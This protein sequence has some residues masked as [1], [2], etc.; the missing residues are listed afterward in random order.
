MAKRDATRATLAVGFILLACAHWAC[1][2]RLDEPQVRTRLVER[3]QLH[4]D[5]LHVR[6]ITR[7]AQPVASIDYGGAPAKLRFRYQDGAWVIDAVEREG[8]WESAD[9]AL[10]DLSRDLPEQARALQMAEVMPRYARTLKV[11]AGWSSLLSAECGSGLPSSER[12]LL[13]LHAVYHRSL[14]ANR[15][16]ADLH[17]PEMFLRDAW[18]KLFHVGFSATR[19]DVQS[20]GGDGRMDTPDDL[21]LTYARTKVRGDVTVCMP[22]FT[23]PAAVAD[24]LG[25]DDAPAAWNCADLIRALKRSEQLAL[26]GDR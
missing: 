4:N 18:W 9:E 15:G 11:L 12:A 21:R 25:R 6:S 24:A 7:E 19:V 1:A 2:P 23:I 20:S 8:R 26:V 22:R 5:Q 14:F 10:R 16:G 13:D 3:L 17:N